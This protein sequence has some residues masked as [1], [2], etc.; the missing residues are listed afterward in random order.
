MAES[1]FD[2]AAEKYG[3]K[4]W[5]YSVNPLPQCGNK[6]EEDMED[7]ITAQ[8]FLQAACRSPYGVRTAALV[9]D[10]VRD[11]PEFG[12]LSKIG[13]LISDGQINKLP[14]LLRPQGEL[15]KGAKLCVLL[16]NKGDGTV[17]AIKTIVFESPTANER[18]HYT[19]LGHFSNVRLQT[20][21]HLK[22]AL[23]AFVVRQMLAW[24]LLAKLQFASSA[25]RNQRSGTIIKRFLASAESVF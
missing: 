1:L 4:E 13:I 5:T 23:R 6:R 22:V 19:L 9:V 7:A 15:P 24:Y 11:V 3:G 25:E 20:L 8:Q 16:Q 14:P 12:A 21:R 10:V 18:L 2:E 17:D